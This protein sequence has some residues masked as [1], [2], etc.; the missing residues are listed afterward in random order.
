MA[1]GK[2]STN[3][4]TSNPIIRLLRRDVGY[5]IGKV[6]VGYVALNSRK[7]DKVPVGLSLSKHSF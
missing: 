3:A 2:Q 6:N 5:I 4:V 7:T 1:S